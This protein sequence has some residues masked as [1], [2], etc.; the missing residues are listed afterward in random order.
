MANL[1]SA[2]T[3]FTAI[4]PKI[5]G[6]GLFSALSI[7]NNLASYGTYNGNTIDGVPLSVNDQG[8]IGITPTQA[9]VYPVGVTP[10]AVAVTP[11]G[12]YAYVANN[13]KLRNKWF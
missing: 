9:K 4:P 3:P 11:D 10:A 1:T 6:D 13:N 7:T 2:F 8:L 12:L 5:P